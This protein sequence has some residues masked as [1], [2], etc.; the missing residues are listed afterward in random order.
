MNRKRIRLAVLLATF[1]AALDGTMVATAGP[2]IARD[3]SGLNLYP[4]M[5]AGFMAA[6]AVA[7]PVFGR[8][9][10]I[11]SPGRL[12][13][14]ALGVFALGSLG[15]ATAVNMSVLIGCRALQGIGAGGIFTVGLIMVGQVFEG[16][17]RAK[18]LGAQSAMWGIAAVFGP[19]VGGLFAEAGLWRWLF[20]IN[21]PLAIAALTLTR[22]MVKP[23]ATRRVAPESE[24]PLFDVA[25]A[26]WLTVSLCALLA[27]PTALAA[28]QG[29]LALAATAAGGIG[30][31]LLWRTERRA[32]HP[33]LPMQKL[34]EAPTLRLLAAGLVSSAVLYA[35]VT[36]IPLLTQN[37]MGLPSA[38]AGLILLPIPVGWAVG[39]MAAGRRCAAAGGRSVASIGLALMTLGVLVCSWRGAGAAQ[40][41]ALA[42]GG[43]LL[44]FGVGHLIIGALWEVQAMAGKRE[45]ALHTG[46]FNFARNLGNALGPA[47]FG[48]LVLLF[49]Q[50][51]MGALAGGGLHGQAAPAALSQAIREVLWILVAVLAILIPV[52]AEFGP[53]ESP[54][55]ELNKT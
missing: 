29:L 39:S 20:L 43:G 22:S 48:G 50:G 26:V 25:G 37:A 38:V 24:A 3:L 15:C 11:F 14:L 18:T 16:S 6:A 55:G 19:V 44:G 35:A 1:L 32:Q 10:D 53:R 5:L 34:R 27:A 13:T 36:V 21:V 28:G 45:M 41:S 17:E 7:T 12:Y 30:C 52:V 47:I 40:A 31:V 49:E 4:W 51:S 54:A 9:A 23:G 33:L 8:L 46:L 42:V 2:A